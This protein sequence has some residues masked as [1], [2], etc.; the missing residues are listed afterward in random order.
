MRKVIFDFYRVFLFINIL[1][2]A[3][4]N[5]TGQT[6]YTL[7]TATTGSTN[8]G[9]VPINTT[10]EKT[11]SQYLVRASELTNLGASSGLIT[12]LALYVTEQPGRDMNN[13]NINLGTT[14]DNSLNNV[15]AGGLSN[16]Y[17]AN[18]QLRTQLTSGGWRTF[19]FNT[20]F[21]WDGTSNM[22]IEFCWDN[23]TL[24]TLGG[25]VRVNEP[26]QSPTY[27]SRWNTMSSAGGCGYTGNAG[28]VSWYRP[29]LQLTI[30][31]CSS[32]SFTINDNACDSYVLNSQTYTASGTYTQTLTNAAGC[33]SIITL[34]L[35]INNNDSTL[36]VTACNSYTFDGNIIVSSGNYSAIFSNSF[37]CDSI[38]TLNL[39]IGN[40]DSTVTV[41]ACDSFSFNG[42]ALTVSDTY[43]ETFANAAGCDSVVTL[44]L[45][46]NNSNGFTFSET[47]CAG[48]NFNGN[49]L[50]D[51]GTYTATHTNASGCDSVVTLHLTILPSHLIYIYDTACVSYVFNNNTLT[52]TGTYSSM[53]FN[54]SGCD[55]LVFLY[56]FIAE[57]SATVNQTACDSFVF[58]G[59]V[60]TVSNTYTAVFTNAAGCDSTVTLTLTIIDNID[61]TVTVAGNV[62]TANAAGADYQWIDCNSN[63]PINNATGQS[64]TAIQ[65][66]NYAVE[67]TD[68]ICVALS[69]CYNIT[70]V[71]IVESE[72][73]QWLVF[74]NPS[75]GKINITSESNRNAIIRI[76]NA[77]GRIVAE[78]KI[79]QKNMVSADLSMLTPGLYIV[80]IV[81][82]EK[83][84]RYRIIRE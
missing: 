70:G 46:V 16:V 32:T 8:A 80:E 54:S 23:G 81:E 56:L 4:S 74:P 83:T 3:V 48:Y 15:F 13:F 73:N 9:L 27:S 51:S 65:N 25:G 12:H 44:H 6:V 63:L 84:F 30:V 5:A 77:I 35:T 68:N 19:T 60:L 29:N 52:A 40:N 24:W 78:E 67:I 59:N 14:T 49:L 17:N 37:G 7:G 50:T 2:G 26:F 55:S 31:D 28:Q 76:L 58:S 39:T 82:D 66:G 71:G 47:V 42:N 21:L 10:L 61:T 20:P 75:S 1:S 43:I 33:D 69:A 57:N 38:V 22:L 34:N 41:T 11:K 79:G 64:F 36:N 72:S 18:P 45:T 62:L 53:F